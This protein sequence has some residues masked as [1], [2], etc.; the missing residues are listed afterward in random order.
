MKNSPA[1]LMYLLWMCSFSACAQQ[2]EKASRE[3]NHTNHL[4]HASSPYLL[5][6]A[7]NPVDWYP[8]GEEALQKAKREDKML[9]IS[10]G[11]AAC[12]WCHVMEKESYEDTSVARLMNQ[13]FVCIK[14]DREER[15]DID[16]VY[17]NAAMLINGNGGW[18]LNVI[19]LPNGQPFFAGTYFPKA[20][21]MKVLNFFARRYR[22]ERK[23]LEEDARQI[24]QGIRRVEAL[25]M[26]MQQRTYHLNDLQA[27]FR[28][29]LPGIDLKEGGNRG[30]PK[31]PIPTD[32]DFLLQYHFL[33][34]DANALKAINTTL[35]HM[36]NGGIY[37]QVGGGF[38]RYATDAS[39][40]VPHF[41]KMLYDNA[42]L[43]SLYSHAY[44]VTQNPL[45]KKVVRQTLAFVTRELMSND[46]AFYSS[47]DAD[48]DGEEGKY[49]VWSAAELK[50]LL[51]ADAALFMDR[52]GASTQGNWKG[53]NVLHIAQST[54]TLAKQYRLSIPV[55]EKKLETDLE[56][57]AHARAKRIAPRLDNK[58]LTA[59]NALM[60]KGFV[61]AYRTFDDSIYLS[62]ALQSAHF[63]EIHLLQPNHALWHNYKDG[64]TSIPGFLDDYAFLAEAF[65]HLYQASFDEHWLYQAKALIDYC[66]LHFYDS[67]TGL[68]FYTDKDHSHLIARKMEISDNVIPASN[69]AIAKDLYLLGLYFDKTDYLQKSAQMLHNVASAVKEDLPYYA[70]WAQ[71]MAWMAEEPYE[72]AIVGRDWKARRRQLDV[73]YLPQMILLGGTDEG[74][75]ALLKDKWVRG[76]TLIYVC[77]QKRCKLPVQ[78]V[79]KALQ[80][81]N[82]NE[83]EQ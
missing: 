52:Y 76:Q 63:L 10:I 45:Y 30:A 21:W 78:E 35:Q 60:L 42:Q 20:D 33:T 50:Q 37:D 31:F 51:G 43:V 40:L 81:M 32:W 77:R 58:V 69:S 68:F 79:S 2:R 15:P 13:Y 38:A 19:A 75:L 66:L 1:V 70:N 14:V 6:H 54:E 64:E 72:V 71:L 80:Q 55:V 3:D 56:Q 11:Y 46:G 74:T 12:H 29:W 8:W 4:I 59:W 36:A 18:P 73:H 49:Y 61:D 83:P 28:K 27:A 24:T 48:S 16:Q 26:L 34:G 17:M 5:E 25:P 53:A 82:A 41:E 67:T 7:H 65:I 47:L 23:K 44:Q 62:Q 22:N 57:L 9:L 39:W